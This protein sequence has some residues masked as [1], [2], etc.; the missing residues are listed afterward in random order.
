MAGNSDYTFLPYLRRGISTQIDKVRS[1]QMGSRNLMPLELQLLKKGPDTEETITIKSNIELYGPGDITGFN[2]NIVIRTDPKANVGTYEPNFC[3]TIEFAEPDFPWRFSPYISEK[4]EGKG[5]GLNPWICLIVL[6]S[7]D[8]QT[9]PEKKEFEFHEPSEVNPIPS[10][11]ILSASSLPSS[12]QAWAWAHVQVLDGGS[13]NPET[14]KTDLEA[15]PE[16][17]SS[18]LVCPR[19]L[20][21]GM[22]YTAFVVPTFEV[23]RQAG[24]GEKVDPYKEVTF[25]WTEGAANIQLPVYYMWSFRT[26]NRGDFE[27]LVRLLRPQEISDKEGKIGKKVFS[28][29][30]PGFDLHLDLTGEKRAFDKFHLSAEGALVAT[31][32][33][34]SPKKVCNEFTDEGKVIGDNF[35][36]FQLGDEAENGL[37]HLIKIQGNDGTVYEK[38]VKPPLYAVGQSSK[39]ILRKDLSEYGDN[40]GWFTQLNLDP[41]HRIAAAYGTRAIQEHQEELMDAAWEQIGAVEEANQRIREAQLA[42]ETSTRIYTKYFE[43]VK[44]NSPADFIALTSSIHRRVSCSIKGI[45]NVAVAL[46]GSTAAN[47]AWSGAFRKVARPGGFMKRTGRPLY[48]NV[49]FKIQKKLIPP[50]WHSLTLFKIYIFL[51]Q[52]TLQLKHQR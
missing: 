52:G 48:S 2:P 16:L 32:F 25:A 39:H 34:P 22:A 40:I 8:S 24:L 30:E 10:I 27:Y 19:K 20:A 28:V 15:H 29:N 45:N 11:T 42:K 44:T 14:F 41:R 49:P 7:Q 33:E 1:A 17:F 51:S 9:G 50:S 37:I 21:P 5:R 35:K 47:I 13:F 31:D 6:R 23:G 46:R 3:P 4:K 43:K 12:D 26:G 36:I 38:Q 18:R